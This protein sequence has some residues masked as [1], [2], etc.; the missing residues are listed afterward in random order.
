MLHLKN[1]HWSVG[2]SHILKGINM[3]VEN[4]EAVGIVGP[5]GCGKTSLLNMINGF[6]TPTQWEIIFQHKNVTSFSVEQRAVAWIGRVFQ[7]FGIFKQLTLQQNLALAFVSKLH[8]RQKLLPLSSLPTSYQAQIDEVLNDLDLYHKKHEKA[9]N[10]SWGQMRLLEIGRLTLQ[11]TKLFLLDEPTAWVAPKLKGTVIKLLHKI[12]QTG[13]MVIIVEHDFG[14]LS[15]FVTKFF[16][17][18]D[19]KKILEWDHATIKQ[20]PIIN[21]IY[22]GK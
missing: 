7:S 22:F 19:G 6:N 16:V 3:T 1:I 21:E 14:F 10:L 11:D 2:K 9:W 8:W 17:M 4:G 20:S 18:D 12:I 5:N 15:E 13:K